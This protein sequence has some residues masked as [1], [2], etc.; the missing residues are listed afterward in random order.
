MRCLCARGSGDATLMRTQMSVT[1]STVSP[2]ALGS[3]NKARRTVIAREKGGKARPNIPV[4][5]VKTVRID[6]VKIALVAVVARRRPATAY[7]SGTVVDASRL[8]FVKTDGQCES[9]SSSVN[10]VRRAS[11]LRRLEVRLSLV[12]ARVNGVPL[13]RARL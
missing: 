5:I 9:V 2:A 10:A 4:K 7:P 13:K 12:K 6:E 8:T 11:A 3:K 1:L